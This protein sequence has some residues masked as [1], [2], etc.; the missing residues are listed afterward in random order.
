MFY[1]PALL[2]NILFFCQNN[3]NTNVYNLPYNS[4]L[5]QPVYESSLPTNTENEVPPPVAPRVDI[6]PSPVPNLHIQPQKISFLGQEIQKK[7]SSTSP[8][9][10]TQSLPQTSAQTPQSPPTSRGRAASTDRLLDRLKFSPAGEARQLL[11]RTR[12]FHLFNLF[13]SA[14]PSY[15]IHQSKHTVINMLTC[16]PIHQKHTEISLLE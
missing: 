14:F 16:T 6:D 3:C 10:K 15:C 8:L 5:Q 2:H 4:L 12:K 9:P 1:C 7:A 13:C 11:K